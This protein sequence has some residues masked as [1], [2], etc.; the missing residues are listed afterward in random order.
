MELESAQIKF[1]ARSMLHTQHLILELSAEAMMILV[2]TYNQCPTSVVVNMTPKQAWSGRQPCVVH[3]RI[4]RCIAFVRVPDVCRTK[5]K[6]NPKKCVFFGY[7]ENTKG[8]KFILVETKRIIGLSNVT[9]CKESTVGHHVKSGP[10][11]RFESAIVN[12]SSK[13]PIVDVDD[14]DE[15]EVD[16]ELEAPS[17]SKTKTGI[18]EMQ[19]K[20]NSSTH[21]R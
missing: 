21:R 19:V 20:N 15:G 5:L 6:A 16:G 11:G 12:M 4:V 8:Y 10:S 14:E 1:M 7:R 2:Y 13:S 18:M 17:R 9:F 3:M